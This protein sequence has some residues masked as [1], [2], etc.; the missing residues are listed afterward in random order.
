MVRLSE[1]EKSFIA[2][3]FRAGAP[4]R[5]IARETGRPIR[6]IRTY[7]ERLRNSPRRPRQRS[8]RQLSLLEREEISRGLAQGR[9]LRVIAARTGR[10]PSTVC[11]EVNRNGGRG[12][13]RA[14]G[15][16]DRAWGCGRRPKSAK[17]AAGTRQTFVREPTRTPVAGTSREDRPGPWTL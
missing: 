12:S 9:S 3:R 5:G 11:R 13:Y 6:T 2:Q 15:A 8:T 17:L 16:E 1:A 14:A 10:Q 4:V 7:L